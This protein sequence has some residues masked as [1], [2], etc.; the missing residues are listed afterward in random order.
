MQHFQIIQY[1]VGDAV[2]SIF[3]KDNWLRLMWTRRLHFMLKVGT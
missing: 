2:L 1:I 3:K